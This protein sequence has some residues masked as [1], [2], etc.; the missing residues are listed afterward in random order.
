MQVEAAQ[1]LGLSGQGTTICVIDT[2][3]DMRSSNFGRD[4]PDGEHCRIAF[5]YNVQTKSEDPVSSVCMQPTPTP[6][7]IPFSTTTRSS[8]RPC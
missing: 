8:R 6:T 5:G 1:R 4:C 3:V 2:G 7:P